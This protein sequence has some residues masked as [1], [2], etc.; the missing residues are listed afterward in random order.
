MILLLSAVWV[1]L[2]AGLIAHAIV[3]FRGYRSLAAATLDDAPSVLAIV[4]ARNE[5]RNIGRCLSGLSAQDYPHARLRVTII[6]D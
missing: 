4:P 5:A 3:Q 2:V 6:D 1:A